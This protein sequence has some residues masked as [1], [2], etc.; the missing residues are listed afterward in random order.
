MEEF[1]Q[2][3][4]SAALYTTITVLGSLVL[5]LAATQLGKAGAMV[6]ISIGPV[7]WITLA[8]GLISAK[9]AINLNKSMKLGA[10]VTYVRAIL[11]VNIILI[12][13][14]VASILIKTL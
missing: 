5:G 7:L 3:S 12:V 14:W 11:S 13:L 2:I 10:N 9:S 4:K 8:I 1:L 6:A